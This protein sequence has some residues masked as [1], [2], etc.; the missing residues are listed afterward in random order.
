MP[1]KNEDLHGMVPDISDVVLI[2]LDVINDLEWEGGELLLPHALAMGRRL[3][4][5]KKGCRKAASRRSTSMTITAAGSP[6]SPASS[7]TASRATSAAD[8]WS[9]C[10]CPRRTITSC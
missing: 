2:L 8:L 7:S 5:L 6:I 4:G 9:R 10:S 1:A 3:A